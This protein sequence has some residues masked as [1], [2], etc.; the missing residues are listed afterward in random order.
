MNGRNFDDT[1]SVRINKEKKEKAKLLGLKLQDLLDEALDN[2]LNL[3]IYDEV[4][5][6]ENEKNELEK[7]MED[8][9]IEEKKELDKIANAYDLKK[10]Q[11]QFKLK[12]INDKITEAKDPTKQIE[13]MKQE[14]FDKVYVKFKESYGNDKDSNFRKALSNY[15]KKYS[16]FDIDEQGKTV[17]KLKE[18]YNNEY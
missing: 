8:L 12:I 16:I 2:Y 10:K 1:T 3:S 5:K 9:E 11:L 18:R 15:C 17:D 7:Q 6:L 4:S 14:D 13:K